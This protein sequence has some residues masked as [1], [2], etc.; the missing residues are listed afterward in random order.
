MFREHGKGRMDHA[1][2]NSYDVAIIGA[3]VGGLSLAYFLQQAGYS[4][5]IL[6]QSS[7]A[8]G[9]IKTKIQDGYLLELGP[10]STL[11]KPALLDLI[12]RLDL[13][14]RVSPLHPQ[15]KKRY[16]LRSASNQTQNYTLEAAPHNPKEL[17]LSRIIP[18]SAKLRLLLEPVMRKGNAEDES[19]ASFMTR[20][21]GRQLT[22]QVISAFFSGIWA[23]DIHALSARSAL[24]Q[25]WEMERSKGSLL[26]GMLSSM[27][28]LAKKR[29]SMITF[30][31]G[32]EVLTESLQQQLL[33][34]TLFL[35]SEVQHL[36]MKGK[37]VT[38]RV[39][40]H[41]QPI[42]ANLVVLTT[43]AKTTAG[44]LRE[45]APSLALQLNSIP[46]APLGIIHLA[47]PHSV[48]KHPLDGYGFLSPGI[49]GQGL[50]GA[51]FSSSVFSK[52]APEG[53]HLLTCFT[54][55]ML[56]PQDALVTDPAV[57]TA[58]VARCNSLIGATENPQVLNVCAYQA[59][60][61]N[62]PIGHFR[63]QDHV[64]AFEQEHP[65]IRILSNWY[66]GL[67]VGDRIEQ[68]SNLH[69]Q[70]LALLKPSQPKSPQ[71]S[72]EEEGLK[73]QFAY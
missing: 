70:I 31:R 64:R 24:P 22:E 49:K 40:N 72:L 5:I 60:I 17:C 36:S 57:Q 14:S 9:W 43:S 33:P 62:Y 21:F 42:N 29:S 34:N 67:G 73:K 69:Q 11:G 54:G 10:N 7:S 59:S 15:A 44:L 2:I 53:H 32:M 41:P 6:E 48:V 55:G 13:N 1:G 39:N 38:L 37:G 4:T 28:T 35:N 18:W 46:Y 52:R 19:V 63:L 26:L 45:Y 65:Q 51:I 71:Q 68:A 23:A 16:L 66:Q 30:D 20:R 58:L 3:G 50:L 56:N 47:Y 27:K 61:P 25:I 12:A 8:G